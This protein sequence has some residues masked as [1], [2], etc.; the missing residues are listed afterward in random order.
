MNGVEP[1]AADSSLKFAPKPEDG[2]WDILRSCWSKYPNIRPQI[3]EVQTRLEE[4]WCQ[5]E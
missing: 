4:I 1:G 5:I 3:D 2:I